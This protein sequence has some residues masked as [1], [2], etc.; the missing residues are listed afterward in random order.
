MKREPHQEVADLSLVM[1]IPRL[2]LR[3]SAISH[4]G[5][6]SDL[7]NERENQGGSQMRASCVSVQFRKHPKHQID[8]AH[9]D[10]LAS[11]GMARTV[12]SQRR[13]DQIPWPSLASR[14]QGVAIPFQGGPYPPP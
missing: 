11:Q 9:E 5:V 13:A 14:N 1:E 8:H 6:Q 10:S 4:H 7:P 2:V 3:P 12:N